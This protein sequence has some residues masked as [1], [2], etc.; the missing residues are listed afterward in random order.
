M[1]GTLELLSEYI[2]KEGSPVAFGGNPKGKVKG[3]GMV[4]KGEIKVN[5]VSYVNGLKHNLI[6]ASQLCDNG[7]D[8]LFKIKLCI[9][10]KCDT[11]IEVMRANRRGDLYLICFDTFQSKEEICL[12]SSIKNEEAWLWH[13]RFCHLNFHTLEKLVKLNL[14]KGLPNIKFEKDHLCSAC[15][16]GKTQ[17][18]FP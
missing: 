17:K 5:Q 3:Y 14:V 8:V 18:I 2:Q 13:T 4:V 1:T 15:E 6:S 7:L 9:M 12:V 11:K 10:Y 16:M